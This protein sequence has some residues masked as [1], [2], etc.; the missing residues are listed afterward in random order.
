MF[1][2]IDEYT[3]FWDKVEDL[4][5]NQKGSVSKV[6]RKANSFKPIPM[7]DPESFI[8]RVVTTGKKYAYL[9]IGEGCSN[10]CTYC[11][12]PYIRGAF[13]SRPMEYIL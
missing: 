6:T 5:K 10:N 2:R 11:A 12:I 3:N 8:E 1:I 4:L 9:K 7:V 13:I